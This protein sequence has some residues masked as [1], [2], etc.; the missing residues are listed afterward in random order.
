VLTDFL[1]GK[2]SDIGDM[3]NHILPMFEIIDVTSPLKEPN[4][5][6]RISAFDY[7]LFDLGVGGF[8]V[9]ANLAGVLIFT[10]IR[11]GKTD[12]WENTLVRPNDGTIKQ[13]PVHASSPLM[14]DIMKRLREVECSITD[15]SQA[16]KDKIIKS[17]KANPQ[18]SQAKAVQFRK[19]DKKLRKGDK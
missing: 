2:R 13:P 3:E 16:Q 14:C 7:T 4:F 8:Y 6:F 10:V 17:I 12:I 9:C 15:I 19:L 18:A 1:L 11:R 5:Y